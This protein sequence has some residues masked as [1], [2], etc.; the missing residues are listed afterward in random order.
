MSK[1][2]T[3]LSYSNPCPGTVSW[4]ATAL[5]CSELYVSS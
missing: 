2:R 3:E 5:R 1:R 4:G